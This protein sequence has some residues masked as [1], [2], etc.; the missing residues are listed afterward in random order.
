MGVAVLL[1]S[2]VAAPKWTTQRAV[3]P[4]LVAHVLDQPSAIDRDLKPTEIGE[5]PVRTHLRPGALFVCDVW[6]GPAVLHVRPSEK[7]LKEISKEFGDIV[8]GDGGFKLSGPL[9]ME[10]D[11]PTL[12][13]L[14]RLVFRFNRRDHGRLRMMIDRLNDMA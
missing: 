14:T 10:F 12:D 11:E 5:I 9:P 7:Q 1:G 6:Y 2:C 13:H 4:E 8:V 3:T